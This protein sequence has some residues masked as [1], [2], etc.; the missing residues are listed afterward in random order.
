MEFDH[1]GLSVNDLSTRNMIIRSNSI[2]LLY[3][4]W[5]PGST[6]PSPGAMVALAA[7][8]HALAAVTPTTWHRRLGH[9]GP[10]AL[11]SLS[12]SSFI[13]YTSNKHEFCHTCQLG[14]HT[15]L[16]FHSSSHRAKH[17]FDLIHLDLWTS[18]IVS[19]SG[20][21]YY[22]VIFDDF[23][24]Y[25]WIFPLKLKSDIFTTLSNFIAYVST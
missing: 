11:S 17:P 7:A 15:R 8:P 14:K 9:P 21:K 4:L 25:L 2:S 6:S 10:D 18:P 5:L 1:F 13:H 22:L 24:Y 3:T 20:S 16:P 12:R 19:V 23:T